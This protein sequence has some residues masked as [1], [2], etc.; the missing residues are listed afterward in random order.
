MFVS[1]CCKDAMTVEGH[2]THYY[3]C[4]KCGRPCDP[5]MSLDLGAM[6]EGEE[7]GDLVTTGTAGFD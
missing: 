4:D 3:V 2:T 5:A 7:Y 6:D 1:K